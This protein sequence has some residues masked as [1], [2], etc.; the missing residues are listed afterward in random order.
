MSCAADLRR[1]V[2]VVALAILAATGAIA[3]VTALG[4]RA[5]ARQALQFDFAGIAS[6]PREVA[7]IWLH[8]ARVLMAP[9]AAAVAVNSPWIVAAVEQRPPR[10]GR[11]WL[12]A[13]LLCDLVLLGAV[14]SNLLVVGASLGAYDLRMLRAIAP[15]GPFE[16]A[17]FSLVLSVYLVARAGPLPV[18]AAVALTVGALVALA[19]GAVVEVYVTL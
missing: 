11:S 7:A 5:D 3:I 14:V 6:S 8:N 18:A 17:A 12:A 9:L 4:F 19:L 16:L 15:H 13:R 1:T 2:V 10:R